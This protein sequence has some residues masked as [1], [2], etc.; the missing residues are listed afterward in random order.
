MDI[1]AISATGDPSSLAS[2]LK[3]RVNI[4]TFSTAYY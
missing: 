1:E 2:Q 4:S 3:H